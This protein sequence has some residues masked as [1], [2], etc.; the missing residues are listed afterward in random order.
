M[1]DMFDMANTDSDQ[2]I[3]GEAQ[4]ISLVG[5]FINRGKLPFKMNG[6]LLFP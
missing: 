4:T 2:E 6:V 5:D 3:E 1:C